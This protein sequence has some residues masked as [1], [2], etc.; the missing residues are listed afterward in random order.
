MSAFYQLPVELLTS[1]AQ[2]VFEETKSFQK[3]KTRR[4]AYPNFA[5]LDYLNAILF[6]NVNFHATPEALDRLKARPLA[7]LT[8]CIKQIAF[9]PSAYS[10]DMTF[11]HFR[12][13]VIKQCLYY[14]SADY[15][16]DEHSTRRG[17]DSVVHLER[18]WVE[19]PLFSPEELLSS[20]QDYRRQ[21]LAAQALLTDGSL[22]VWTDTFRE[23][24][25]VETFEYAKLQE[26]RRERETPWISRDLTDPW[27][28][29]ER[30]N[31]QPFE[32]RKFSPELPSGQHLYALPG[33]RVCR[34]LPDHPHDH[35]H[36]RP[37]GEEYHTLS[38]CR[39]NVKQMQIGLVEPASACINEAGAQPQKLILSSALATFEPLPG[40]PLPPNLQSLDLSRLRSLVWRTEV[41]RDEGDRKHWLFERIYE[42]GWFVTALLRKCSHSL[43]ELRIVLSNDQFEAENAYRPYWPPPAAKQ[44][45]LPACVDCKSQAP[46]RPE[47]SPPGLH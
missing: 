9:L 42:R 5:N 47:D 13:I 17:A 31:N 28:D 44:L 46:R 22:R 33:E 41:S 40:S 8:S 11:L 35:V 14:C 20:F 7:A 19:E 36:G 4:L 24:P 18:I 2:S 39:T 43:Q 10:I 16:L 6:H 30:Y 38:L 37:R 26:H 25:H 29:S 15:S 21:A 45:E 23:L 1:I 12:R 3:G 32:E 34:I 27:E